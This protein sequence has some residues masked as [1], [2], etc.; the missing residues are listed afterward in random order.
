M[1][2][3][4]EA[5]ARAVLYEG[6]N[7]YPY[8][9][10]SL[11]NRHRWT[12]GSVF[13]RAWA[14]HDGSYRSAMQT[15]C[16][17]EGGAQSVVE[18]RVRFLHIAARE[19]G[20]PVEP[21][22]ELP[23]HGDPPF[24]K[25]PVFDLDGVRHVEWEESEERTVAAPPLA[26]GSLAAIGETVRFTFPAARSI[27]PLR[28]IDGKIA[29]LQI[30][31]MSAVAGIVEISAETVA[32]GVYRVTVRIENLTPLADPA[33][34]ERAA[35]QRLAF[36]ST[37]TMLTVR[38]GRFL[39][40]LDPPAALR[41]EAAACRNEGTWPVLVGEEG[42]AD[43]MLSSPIILY[44]YPKIAPESPGDL[45][46]G[47]EIDEILTLR[48]LTMTEAEKREMA[49]TDPRA[50]ALLERAEALGPD[51]MDRLHGTLRK[52][53]LAS[54]EQGGRRFAVGDR[55]KL[56]PR[57]GADAMDVVLAGLTAI[58]EDIERDFENRIHLAVTIE[59]DPGRDLGSDRFPGHR[60][61]YAV[62]EVEPLATEAAS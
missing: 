23:A 11:K 29:A 32:G 1:T 55:V 22:A 33:G 58:V 56:R 16:L 27:A 51:D 61:F 44:D 9:P 24:R 52:P 37:H 39:S 10:S 35:V 28:A 13:P 18:I 31:T 40:L 41:E 4:V 46:D 20:E 12:F 3:P 42:Q 38:G 8:R 14:D 60:F 45:F 54:I 47:C 62:D 2:D 36:A 15:Q 30:R 48:I 19:I 49:A 53:R 25:V 7:L 57:G 59:D 50:R 5:I 34:M 6:Y 21:I 43:A 26:V 17:V